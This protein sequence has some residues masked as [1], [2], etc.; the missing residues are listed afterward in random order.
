MTDQA[1]VK[2]VSV[3]GSGD[4]TPAGSSDTFYKFEYTLDNGVAGM[5]F[6]KSDTAKFLVGDVVEAE[7]TGQFKDGTNKLK[8]R[9]PGTRPSSAYSSGGGGGGDKMSKE[10]WAKK[11]FDVTKQWAI[12]SAQNFL[13]SGSVNPP[14]IKLRD[15]AA[16][17]QELIKMRDDLP[18]YI[19]YAKEERLKGNTDLPF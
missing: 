16:V 10:E 15:V 5:A 13:F 19:E 9:K 2:V 6:H 7:V 1:E 4:W 17:A 14:D 8:L 12:N 3:Q 18:G 11:D